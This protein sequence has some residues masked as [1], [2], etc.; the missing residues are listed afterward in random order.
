MRKA[1]LLPSGGSGDL[2][3]LRIGLPGNPVYSLAGPDLKEG[4]A[5]D[6]V[7]SNTICLVIPAVVTLP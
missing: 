1:S 2:E 6:A 4:P 5:I 3:S 7:P